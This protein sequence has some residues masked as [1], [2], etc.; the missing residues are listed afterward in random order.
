MRLTVT[1]V[2]FVLYCLVSKV[3]SQSQNQP[4][5]DFE[6]AKQE[7]EDFLA[8]QFDENSPGIAIAVLKKNQTLFQKC[9]GTRNL[10]AIEPIDETT[11]FSTASVSKQF[12][13]MALLILANETD[14]K[15]DEPAR[16]YLPELNSCASE[17]TLRQMANHTSGI[18]SHKHLFGLKGFNPHDSL[19]REMVHQII[20]AQRQLNFHPG[21]AFNYSNSGYALLAEVIERKS[22]ISFPEFV[23]QKIL[24]PLEM[25]DSFFVVDFLDP[26]A[27]LANAYSRDG[28]SY[29]RIPSNDSIVGSTGLFTTLTDL[30]KWAANFSE[31]KVG[32][33]A[34]LAAMEEP[35]V[36]NSGNSTSYGLG[37]FLGTHRREKMIYHAGSDA[38]FVCFVAYFP[39][40]ELSVVLLANCSSIP[41]QHVALSTVEKFLPKSGGGEHPKLPLKPIVQLTQ[42]QLDRYSGRYFDT[43]NYIPRT[44]RSKEMTL[45]YVR[46]EQGN[47][48]SQLSP[49]GNHQFHLKNADDVVV[50]FELEKSPRLMRVIANGDIVETYEE[51]LPSVPT[52]ADLN[53][54][55]GDY[56]S[57]E[58]GIE[59][60]IQASNGF[61][62]ARIPRGGQVRLRPIKSNCF[63]ATGAPFEFIEFQPR[64]EDNPSQSFHVSTKR[65]NKVVFRRKN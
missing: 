47:R 26:P 21:E 61:L 48:T 45:L 14:V 46:P 3:Q 60:S 8:Q 12:T 9:I 25:K 22:G 2:L 54:Y 16:K 29:N 51:F 52:K 35:G 63:L 13:S 24:S 37:L 36:L 43:T 19:T 17:V 20:F 30:K 32:D 11:V 18:R 49:I 55:A 64:S 23:Q 42:S 58:L 65:A 1:L 4:N 27:Q 5:Q 59:Y 39:E 15:L 56:F 41:S 50:E 10:A 40:S 6:I 34:M 31:L 62:Q 44:I 33:K 57:E 28:G 7:A 53:S 38:G